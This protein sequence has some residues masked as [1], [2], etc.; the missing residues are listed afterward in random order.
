MT[1]YLLIFECVEVEMI[2]ILS[3]LIVIQC[4]VSVL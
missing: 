4:V 3:Q 2:E 1:G